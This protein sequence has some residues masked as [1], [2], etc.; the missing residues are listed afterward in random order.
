[1]AT[2]ESRTAR[3]GYRAHERI[4]VAEVVRL[5]ELAYRHCIWLDID[6]EETPEQLAES[7]LNQFEALLADHAE[8]AGYPIRGEGY[9]RMV[10]D[11]AATIPPGWR[12][13]WHW[14]GRKP[15][16]KR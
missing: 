12:P 4:N 3:S 8:I 11:D 13:G 9:G 2:R 10:A 5:A 1:M 14:P 16:N 6:Q 15:S 7:V